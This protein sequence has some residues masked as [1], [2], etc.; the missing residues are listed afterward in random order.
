M[1]I[2]FIFIITSSIQDV[3]VRK[4][5]KLPFILGVGTGLFLFI[6]SPLLINLAVFVIIL[7][8]GI[9]LSKLNVLGGADSKILA[10]LMLGIHQEYWLLYGVSIFVAVNITLVIW[11]LGY[12]ICTKERKCAYRERGIPLIPAISLPA[13]LFIFL[14]MQG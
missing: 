2:L 12:L 6:Q 14:S 9:F 7:V 10:I 1:I 13:P 3:V 11:L 5:G 4:I 8:I